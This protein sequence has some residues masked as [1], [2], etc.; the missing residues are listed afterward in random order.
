[1]VQGGMNIVKYLLFAFNLIFVIFGILL[2]YFGLATIGPFD[3]W[4]HIIKDGP[5]SGSAITLIVIGVIIFFIAFL[6][7]C[8]A[9][10]ENHCMLVTFG[11]IILIILLVEL[12]G[13]GLIL[14]YRS[15]VKEA[16]ESGIQEA[17]KGYNSSAHDSEINKVLDDLQSTFKCCGGKNLSDYDH[18]KPAGLEPG[19]YP[20]SCCA[21]KTVDDTCLP[22]DVKASEREGGCVDSLENQI[23][24]SLGALGGIAISIAFIQLIGVVF[25]CCLGRSIRKEYEVV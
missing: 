24:G 14:G 16:V 15:K 19:H 6:G 25:A 23:K 5:P 18:I 22:Q 9:L 3:R 8:G 10:R 20:Y 12:I 1:M 17:I 2:I 21:N 4:A 7:C 13:A 11:G